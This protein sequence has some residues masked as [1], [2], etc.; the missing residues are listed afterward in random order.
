M[1]N[2]PKS[3]GDRRSFPHRSIPVHARPSEERQCRKI[4]EVALVL[5]EKLPHFVRDGG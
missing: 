2:E 3:N 4:L 1:E 5:P